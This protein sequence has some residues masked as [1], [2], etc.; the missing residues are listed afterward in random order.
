[1]RGS[2]LKNLAPR[3][4]WKFIPHLEDKVSVVEG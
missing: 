2:F 3:V 4:M 1:M